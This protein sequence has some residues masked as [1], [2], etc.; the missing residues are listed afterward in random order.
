[1]GDGSKPK[2][3]EPKD[4]PYWSI[5]LEVSE[6]S[7]KPVDQANILRDSI[8]GLINTQMIKPTDEIVSTY[9]RRFDHGYPTPSLEREG[10]LKELLPK[11]QARDIYSRGRFGSWRYEVGNQDHSFMLGVEAADNIV[12][13]AV[14]LTLNY[15]DFVNGRQ[16]TERR[17]FE[18]SQVFRNKATDKADA[19]GDAKVVDI[20]AN[21]AGIANGT[22]DVPT[23]DRA[24]SKSQSSHGRKTSKSV[25]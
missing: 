5:M 2:S 8:Q 18:G 21:K 15:P 22:K 24:P 13:G 9:H 10:V 12:N 6:S 7:M 3:S 20:E 14:E 1:M 16:N 25:K 4:G 17:L 23:R 19:A 11:L